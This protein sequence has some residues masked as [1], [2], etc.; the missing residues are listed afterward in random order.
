MLLI[1]KIYIF[2]NLIKYYKFSILSLYNF[3]S[4]SIYDIV[5]IGN[6]IL[7][8]NNDERCSMFVFL[9]LKKNVYIRLSSRR[10]CQTIHWSFVRSANRYVLIYRISTEYRWNDWQNFKISFTILQLN[11]IITVNKTK[12]SI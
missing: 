10:F 4:V 2:H 9:E 7:L 11:T 8:L 12:M 6:I 3:L 5:I 1:N